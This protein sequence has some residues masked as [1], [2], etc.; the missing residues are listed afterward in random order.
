MTVSGLYAQP[1]ERGSVRWESGKKLGLNDHA[2][3]G[4]PGECDARTQQRADQR[5]Q[6]A[7][8]SFC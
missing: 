8:A 1:E 7:R 5:V 4:L 2:V 3:A 6:P